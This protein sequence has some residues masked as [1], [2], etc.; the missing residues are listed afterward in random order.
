MTRLVDR[1]MQHQTAQ[2]GFAFGGGEW[3]WYPELEAMGFDGG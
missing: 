2:C 3:Y 1:V